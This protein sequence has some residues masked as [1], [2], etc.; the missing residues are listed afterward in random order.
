MSSQGAGNAI[1][2]LQAPMAPTAN[3]PMA[4]E[5]TTRTA[6]QQQAITKARNAKYGG[7]DGVVGLDVGNNPLG[8]AAK[9]LTAWGLAKK[10]KKAN[11]AAAEELGVA[12]DAENVI[13]AKALAKK[14]ADRVAE[15]KAKVDAAAL[16]N[17][18]KIIAA[19]TA[20]EV[21]AVKARLALEGKPPERGYTTVQEGGENVTYPT[22]DG[23]ISGPSVGTGPKWKDDKA[24]KA[25]KADKGSGGYQSMTDRVALLDEWIEGGY[26]RTGT[27]NWLESTAKKGLITTGVAK[28]TS[29]RMGEL[30]EQMGVGQMNA[31]LDKLST[32]EGFSSKNW[33]TTGER[34]L[35]L[36]T[37]SDPSQ[38]AFTQYSTLAGLAERAAEGSELAALGP[39]LRAKAQKYKTDADVAAEA[40]NSLT[41][42][43]LETLGQPTQEEI[44]AELK[45]R[46]LL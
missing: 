8:A 1:D 26:G 24:D 12:A 13:L 29:G 23:V 18:N 19:K 37:L 3:I 39:M 32:T 25:D 34:N 6:L 38:S 27:D 11:E 41:A 20:A 30:Q 10:G 7:V 31:F 42:E 22:E 44:N 15:I 35:I 21:A 28:L 2:S 16:A 43:A 9:V 5:A 45:R 33:D 4:E 17:T 14:E 36:E 46:G 40:P